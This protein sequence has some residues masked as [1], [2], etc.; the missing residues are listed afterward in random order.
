[1]KT[2]VTKVQI[3]TKTNFYETHS[4]DIISLFTSTSASWL[5]PKI[6]DQIGNLDSKDDALKIMVRQTKV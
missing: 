5:Y 2:C 4:L 3:K 6:D 1:M